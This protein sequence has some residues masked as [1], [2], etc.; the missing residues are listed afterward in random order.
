MKDPCS[1]FWSAIL[2]C[3]IILANMYNGANIKNIVSQVRNRWW[4]MISFDIG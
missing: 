3:R 4:C 2:W 1:S